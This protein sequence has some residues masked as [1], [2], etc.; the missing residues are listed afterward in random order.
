MNSSSALD[1]PGLK[2]GPIKIYYYGLILAVALLVG[3]S[4]ARRRAK[5]FQVP[6]ALID[7]A[8]LVVALLAIIG[9]RLYFILF[10]LDYYRADPWQVLDLQGGGLAIH[11]ALLGGAVG[12]WLVWRRYR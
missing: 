5:L 4:W 7:S 6:P 8:L 2:L 11:G 10:N 12:L 1:N 3:Y 9:A